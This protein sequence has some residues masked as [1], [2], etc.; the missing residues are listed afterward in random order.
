[1][2]TNSK[3]TLQELGISP[4]TIHGLRHTHAS[5]L[6]YMKIDINYVC[7]HLGHSNI[8]TTY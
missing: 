5:V 7:E 4:M 2:P 6:L 3:K 1:M 8:E